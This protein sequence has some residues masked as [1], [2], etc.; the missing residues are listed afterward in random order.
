MRIPSHAEFLD[1]ILERARFIS[2]S[3]FFVFHYCSQRAPVVGIVFRRGGGASSVWLRSA[4]EQGLQS[5]LVPTDGCLAPQQTLHAVAQP[6]QSR[7]IL[8]M[9]NDLSLI[10]LAYLAQH[11]IEEDFCAGACFFNLSLKLHV[12]LQHF[13]YIPTPIECSDE[14][15]LCFSPLAAQRYQ[16]YF[17]N[18]IS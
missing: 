14:L 9:C 4:L 1:Q 8:L 12:I 11:L 7:F 2:G 18:R 13:T 3:C 6:T 15:S 10:V 16:C 5:P 17:G